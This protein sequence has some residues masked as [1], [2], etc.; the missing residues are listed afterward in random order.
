VF[1]AR[2][3]GDCGSAPPYQCHEPNGSVPLP[4]IENYH[5]RIDPDSLYVCD[6]LLGWE[7]HFPWP[8]PSQIDIE[9]HCIGACG[10][11]CST[12]TCTR[13]PTSGYI[14]VGGGQA[15]RDTHD[16]CYA[17]DC[18]WYHDLCGRM[19]P[20][21]V[22]TD[23]FCHALAI[24][25]GCVACIGSGFPG[26]SSPP[27]YTTGFDHPY[28]DR[29][30]CTTTC[31]DRPGDCY[32]DCTGQCWPG[33]DVNFDCYD[34]CTGQYICDPCGGDPCCGDPCCGDP[35]CGD[36]ECEFSKAPGP[37]GGPASSVAHPVNSASRAAAAVA[38]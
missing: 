20:T 8:Q 29:R 18:C 14:D 3:G 2:G 36:P 5:V 33:C 1:S 17:S 16:S 10:A 24:V 31:T 37:G 30:D 28:T 11:D 23:P 15:C 27:S 12:S 7:S 9:A 32:D 4:G 21:A 19:F 26:C 38:R 6:T 13:T 34:D 25:Y 22:F 35:C